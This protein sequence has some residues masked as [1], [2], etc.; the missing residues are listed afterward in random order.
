MY[1]SAHR[2]LRSC[3]LG[4]LRNPIRRMAVKLGADG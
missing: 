1:R 3:G 4:Q 2:Y